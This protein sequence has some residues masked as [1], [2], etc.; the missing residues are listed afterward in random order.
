MKGEDVK[1]SLKHVVLW[2]DMKNSEQSFNS[3]KKKK[4]KK[5]NNNNNNN[6]KQTNI[7]LFH[8]GKKTFFSNK[9]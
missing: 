5:K 7:L 2:A 9:Q 6:N 3:K 1:S 4:K 8:R